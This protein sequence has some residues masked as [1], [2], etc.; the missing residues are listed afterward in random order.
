MKK[1]CI[2]D[3]SVCDFLE[4]L[5]DRNYECLSDCTV[6]EPCENTV[7]QRQPCFAQASNKQEGHNFLDQVNELYCWQEQD[8]EKEFRFIPCE[9]KQEPGPDT[10]TP[11]LELA[12][13]SRPFIEMVSEKVSPPAEAVIEKKADSTSSEPVVSERKEEA[14]PAA[15]T[16]PTS[17]RKSQV[18]NSRMTKYRTSVLQVAEKSNNNPLVAKVQSFIADPGPTQD[19]L[20]KL[21]NEILQ[22]KAPKVKGVKKLTKVQVNDLVQNCIAYYLDKIC[23][24][25]K[26]MEK[27]RRS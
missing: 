8:C 1:T 4:F 16:T 13:H 12:V 3:F 18:V 26:D 27:V 5:F 23:F 21:V 20:E 9:R 25:G 17:K 7:A 22:N 19:R 10:P 2:D 11:I 14:L 6:C 15:T 24:N